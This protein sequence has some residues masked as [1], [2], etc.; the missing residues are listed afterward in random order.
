MSKVR[1]E[2]SIRFSAS[3]S[4]VSSW[5]AKNHELGIDSSR[6]VAG[7]G[8]AAVGAVVFNEAVRAASMLKGSPVR[9]DGRERAEVM[10]V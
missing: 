6:E 4:G 5:M 1:V 2:C 10:G 9:A 8:K 3:S 7:F